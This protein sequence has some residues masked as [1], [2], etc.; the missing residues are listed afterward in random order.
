MEKDEFLCKNGRIHFVGVGGI[1]MCALAKFMLKKGYKVSGSDLNRSRITDDLRA[2]GVSIFIGHR[3]ENVGDAQ[4]VVYTSAI[5]ENNPEMKAARRDGKLLLSRTALLSYLANQYP[6]TVAICGSHG[7]TTATSMTAHVM[8]AGGVKLT[9]HIGGM[10]KKLGNLYYGGDACFLTEACEY[11]KNFL[12]LYPDITVMLNL[13]KDHMECYDGEGDLYASFSQFANQS[14]VTIVNGDDKKLCQS[15]RADVLFSVGGEGDY[16]ATDWSTEKGK[17]IFTARLK[18]GKTAQFLVKGC[19]KHVVY[20]AIAT[21]A[22]CAE[23]GISVSKIQKG[24]KSYRGVER[25]MEKIGKFGAKNC[26]IDYAHHPTEISTTVKAFM[27]EFG[28]NLTV[29]FQPHTYSR[30]SYLFDDFVQVLSQFPRVILYPTYPAREAYRENGS[31]DTLCRALPHA[32]YA[33]S[34]SALCSLLS[35]DKKCKGNVLFVGAGDIAE[36]AREMIK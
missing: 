16:V 4:V 3:A 6:Q 17:T 33:A 24:L 18:N 1:S 34:K 27:K 19:G 11:K 23:Y 30:T 14:H 36:I 25:R 7:K 12:S 32:E 13:Q 26:Y 10:D 15:V 8:R 9:A 22:V 5:P 31:A 2:L 20:N 29:V 28:D 21:V 35:V